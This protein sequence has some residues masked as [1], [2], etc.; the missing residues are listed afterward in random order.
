[1]SDDGFDDLIEPSTHPF[2][3]EIRK[4]PRGK[5]LVIWQEREDGWRLTRIDAGGQVGQAEGRNR[6]ELIRRAPL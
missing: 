4:R 3:T 2:F 5:I 6:S 1:M